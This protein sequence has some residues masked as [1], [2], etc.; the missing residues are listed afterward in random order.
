MKKVIAKLSGKVTLQVR[1]TFK[2]IYNYGVNMSKND[3][4]KFT[5]KEALIKNAQ[6]LGLNTV[7]KYQFLVIKLST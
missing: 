1:L 2:L 5:I 3:D 6:Y 7:Y 4:G